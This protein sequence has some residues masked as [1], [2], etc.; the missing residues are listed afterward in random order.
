MQ[1][2]LT[3]KPD[4]SQAR[5]NLGLS[6]YEQGRL[7][8]AHDCFATVLAQ[9]PTYANARINLANTLRIL[10]RP[11]EARLQLEQHLADHPASADVLNNLGTVLQDL[12]QAEQARDC[13]QRA[14]AL[15]P[16]SQQARWNLSL[17]QLLLGDYAEGWANFE[18]RWVGCANLNGAYDKP[19]QSE[20]RGEALS[21]KRLLLWAEQGFGDTLQFIRFAE[22]LAEQGAT[23]IVEA[24]P[25]LLDLL[26]R[27]PG[28]SLA[29]AR[30]QA[31]PPYDLHC[32]LMSLPHRLG[33]TLSAPLTTGAYLH[34]DRERVTHWKERLAHVAGNKVGLTWAGKSRL[35]NAELAAIDA[36][37]SIKLRQVAPLLQHA[38]CSFFS[39]QKGAPAVE[40]RETG[41]PLQDFSDEWGDFADTA[42]FIANLDLVI[43]VDTAVAHLAGALGKPVW[44]LNRYD[45]CWRWLLERADSPWYPTMRQFRQ[46]SAGDWDT[47]IR[48]V[49]DALQSLQFAGKI[50]RFATM[51]GPTMT[52]ADT[53]FPFGRR[54]HVPAVC[55]I[56]Y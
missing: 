30:G 7:E 35:Q 23:V 36:R 55:A 21:G 53:V 31:L 2:L 6:Y 4:L 19:T 37:R 54:L 43:T 8:E 46:T 41:L 24:Q 39:L 13:L 14:L 15:S 17:S 45:T 26:A 20:W 9:D 27:A 51:Q 3:I 40:L 5:N 52:T 16:Q 50:G 29:L 28:V 12:G 25:E 56:V 1:R 42:A 10:G 38:H 18:A 49:S 33:I 32:P 44:L 48:S 34:A 11:E 22:R 47:V